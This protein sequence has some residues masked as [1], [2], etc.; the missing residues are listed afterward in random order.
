MPG[1]NRPGADFDAE[2]RIPEIVCLNCKRDGATR[3]ARGVAGP[4]SSP[5]AAKIKAAPFS[6]FQS[7][8]VMFLSVSVSD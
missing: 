8:E 4:K 5:K 2:R 3:A 7:V 6:G 1:V